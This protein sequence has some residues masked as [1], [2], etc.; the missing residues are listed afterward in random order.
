MGLREKMIRIGWVV[1]ALAAACCAVLAAFEPLY[2]ITECEIMPRNGQECGQS[3]YSYFGPVLV[4]VLAVPVL[5]C[6]VPVIWPRKATGWIAAL[7]L[8]VVSIAGLGSLDTMI[9]PLVYFFPF[10]LVTVLFAALY[11]PLHQ[12]SVRAESNNRVLIE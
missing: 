10:A 4:A 6:V 5:L 3:I 9:A 7:G 12:W 2:Q 1:L 11:G 8:V